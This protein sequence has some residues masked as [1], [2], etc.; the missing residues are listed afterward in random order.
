MTQP[1]PQ[2]LAWFVNREKQR[3]GFMKMLARET[4]KQIMLVEAPANMGKTWLIQV[5][6]H[7]CRARNVPVAHFDFRDRRP[8]DYLTL[9]RQA[10]DQ[11]DPA[12]FNEMTQIINQLTGVEIRLTGAPGEGRVDLDIASEGGT[13]ADSTV[14]MGD[15]AGR[16]I[17]KD[18]FFFVK[19]DSETAR[20]A[21]EIRITDAFFACLVRFTETRIAVFLFDSY[22]VV[23]P[24][25]DTWIQGQFLPRIRD[26]QLP[27][28]LTVLAGRQVPHLDSGWRHV[29][30]RT[31]LEPFD[32]QCV[33]EYIVEKRGLADL[34]VD[35]IWRTSGGNPGLLGMMADTAAAL[36]GDEDDWP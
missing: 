14:S 23:T 6:R 10:R 32:P 2:Y 30:A 13:I 7:E 28:V 15:V 8:W 24:E 11:L 36:T 35:T 1:E 18:N 33:R 4:P 21:V 25:A 26:G 16:D 29:V 19:A 34:D 17:I 9:V 3:Q 31:G 12:A 22:E 20:R 5:L 27:N